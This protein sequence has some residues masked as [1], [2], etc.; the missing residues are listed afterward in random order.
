MTPPKPIQIPTNNGVALR[1]VLVYQAGLANVFSVPQC[2][3]CE[4]PT[5]R[6][7]SRIYQGDFRTAE[8]ICYGAGLAGAIVRTF[9]C[10]MAGDISYQPWTADLD[11]Q[12]FSDRF[13]P[14]VWNG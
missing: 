4:A 11:S 2:L 12:P 13:H 14:Q 10:N 5:D 8:S 9:A 7:A 3:G 1:L 6:N